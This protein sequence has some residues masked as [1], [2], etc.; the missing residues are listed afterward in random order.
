MD[1]LTQV[2]EW[3]QVSQLGM[4][5]TNNDNFIKT[6]HRIDSD[7]VKFAEAFIGKTEPKTE[8]PEEEQKL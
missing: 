8:P 6:L 5:K 2:H 7:K 1:Q 4:A 3:S